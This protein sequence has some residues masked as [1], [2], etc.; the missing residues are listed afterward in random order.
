MARKKFENTGEY[1]KYFDSRYPPSVPETGFEMKPG[2]ALFKGPLQDAVKLAQETNDSAFED[3]RLSVVRGKRQ[4][5]YPVMA[6]MV[7]KDMGPVQEAM[8]EMLAVDI[9]TEHKPF[10]VET[11]EGEYECLGGPGSA[12]PFKT[13]R[14]PTYDP[15]KSETISEQ[16]SAGKAAE[17]GDVF[18]WRT[19]L[20]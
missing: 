15:S 14:A 2:K 18:E 6:L 4:F 9:D 5:A 3:C 19:N 13:E 20:F 11:G 1:N 7:N 12:N 8:E 10:V 17:K 16:L